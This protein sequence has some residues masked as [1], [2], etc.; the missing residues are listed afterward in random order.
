MKRNIIVS[1]VLLLS[2]SVKAQT[3]DVATTEKI[4]R[5]NVFNPAIELEIP[6][7]NN[8][9]FSSSVGIGYGGGYPDL[10]FYTGSAT[11]LIIIVT[12]FLDIQEKWFYN[13]K[14]RTRKSKNTSHNSANFVSARLFAR[15]P[16]IYENWGRTSDFDVTIGPTWGIQ[17]K[18]WKNFHL[19]FDVGP[20]FYFDTK[21]NG[22]VFPIIVQL[23]VGF[24]LLK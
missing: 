18:F 21:G 9:S 2:L 23:N 19:L 15:G 4:W 14:R 24:D 16:S 17:R 3:E 20:V 22:G 7:G 13:F 12:P 6:T 5:I 11:D 10:T 1:L 8:F